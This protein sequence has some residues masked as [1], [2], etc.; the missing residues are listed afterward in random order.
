MKFDS[1]NKVVKTTG[2][3]VINETVEVSKITTGRIAYNNARLLLKP[4]MPKVKWYEKLFVNS[5]KRELV[6]MLIVYTA[7]HMFKHKFDNYATDA[8]TKYINYELQTNVLGSIKGVDFDNLF[9]LAK[10]VK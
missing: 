7:V 10:E 5:K 1:L 2:D 6:E 9:N 8:I 4:I 3:N